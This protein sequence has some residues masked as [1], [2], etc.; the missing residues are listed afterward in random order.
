MASSVLRHQTWSEETLIDTLPTLRDLAFLKL[1]GTGGSSHVYLAKQSPTQRTVAVKVIKK[2]GR[3]KTRNGVLRE[4]RIQAAICPSFFAPLL[5]SFH[6]TANFYL[7]MEYIPGGDLATELLRCK[8]FDQKRCQF[9]TAELTIALEA[10]HFRGIIHRDLKPANVL[11]RRDGHLV[12]ADFGHARYLARGEM[13]NELCGT[14]LFMCPEQHL[15]Q[16]YSFDADFWALGVVLYR[17]LTGKMPWNEDDVLEGSTPDLHGLD[18]AAVELLMKLLSTCRGYRPSCAWDIKPLAFFRGITWDLLVRRETHAPWL[19]WCASQPKHPKPDVP[20]QFG[21]QYQ[22]KDDP[23][24]DFTWVS[25][26]DLHNDEED[27]E[28]PAWERLRTW[29]RAVFCLGFDDV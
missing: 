16:M 29:L 7:V 24:P 11:F 22:A 23:C 12:V 27:E 4:R 9:Y 19:T 10:L 15:G 5:A 1:L 14:P 3:S 2:H 6:D 13:T 18:E 20:F 21:V 28:G 8:R 17:M 25:A 26:R